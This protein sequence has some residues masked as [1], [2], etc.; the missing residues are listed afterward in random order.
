[1]GF[2]VN[3]LVSDKA[4]SFEEWNSICSS[5]VRLWHFVTCFL[6]YTYMTLYGFRKKDVTGYE[7]KTDQLN[8]TCGRIYS[9]AA[10][11][12]RLKTMIYKYG[13]F[14]FYWDSLTS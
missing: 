7:I 14:S 11:G 3:N 4:W 1:M 6:N 2:L 10:Q 9:Y 5:D 8:S 13:H 12:D